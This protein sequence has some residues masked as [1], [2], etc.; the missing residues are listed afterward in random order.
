M[1]LSHEPTGDQ[2]ASTVPVDLSLPRR[3]L[4]KVAAQP[5]HSHSGK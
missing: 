3:A 2:H 5:F 4:T 1:P